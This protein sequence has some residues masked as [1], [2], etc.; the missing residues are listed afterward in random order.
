MSKVSKSRIMFLISFILIFVSVSNV[1]AFGRGHKS[2]Y[3]YTIPEGY[4]LN[5]LDLEDGVYTGEA[6]GFRPGFIV[7][8]TIEN[9]KI[10]NIEVIDHNEV[11]PQYFMRPISIIPGEIVREEQSKVDAVSGATATSNAIMS[12][13]EDALSLKN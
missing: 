5:A 11:G 9:Q 3:D 6:V 8:V 1:I 10:I 2:P 13:V 12:A 7:E 4:S